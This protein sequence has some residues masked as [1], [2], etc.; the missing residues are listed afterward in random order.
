MPTKAVV[1]FSGLISRWDQRQDRSNESSDPA[2]TGA[3]LGEV[4]PALELSVGRLAGPALTGVAAL[5]SAG[6]RV[7]ARL[8]PEGKLSSAL[9]T[10]PMGVRWWRTTVIRHGGCARSAP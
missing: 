5:T 7:Q 10:R 6:C 2:G 9:C 1:S 8:G 3:D 4:I